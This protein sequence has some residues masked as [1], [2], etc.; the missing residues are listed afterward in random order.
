MW[1]GGTQQTGVAPS[2]VG[3]LAPAKLEHDRIG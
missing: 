1:R 2:Q 3:T